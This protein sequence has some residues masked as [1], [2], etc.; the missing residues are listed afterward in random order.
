M[1]VFVGNTALH[2]CAESGSL[3]IMKLLFTFGAVIEKDSYGLTP[4]LAAAVAGHARIV[5]YLT[6]LPQCSVADRIDALQLLGATFV[7]KKRDVASAAK[8]WKIAMLERQLAKPGTLPDVLTAPVAAYSNASEPRTTGELAELILDPDTVRM[9]ALCVRE[10]ILGAVH[11]DTAYYVRYRGAVYA[12]SGDFARC[13]LLWTHAVDMQRSHLEPLSVATQ[14]QL[15][16]IV[17]LIN[18]II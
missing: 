8:V 7:D 6:S 2:D 9:N 13:I 4:L 18:L 3:E 16:F 10:R 14:V 11:P 15:L 12:D 17:S 1:L 5:E